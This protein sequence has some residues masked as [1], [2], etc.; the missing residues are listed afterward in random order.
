MQC[1]HN[2]VTPNIDFDTYTWRA[3]RRS[4][5][6]AESGRDTRVR[7]SMHIRV[8]TRLRRLCRASVYTCD[9]RG[10]HNHVESVHA[11][12]THKSHTRGARNHSNV[13]SIH[14]R[15]RIRGARVKF[16]YPHI[17]R[18]KIHV[19]LVPGSYAT[20]FETRIECYKIAIR[21]SVCTSQKS[22]ID[23]T[24]INQ[25]TGDILEKYE[26]KNLIADLLKQWSFIFHD[27]TIS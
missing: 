17:V 19:P 3:A 1:Y 11:H 12:Q 9:I 14:A 20:A 15:C 25:V 16:T 6:N 22:N 27:F 18:S 21:S 10:K 13:R 7:L 24:T 26:F 4:Y 2:L 5:I 8:C 23:S